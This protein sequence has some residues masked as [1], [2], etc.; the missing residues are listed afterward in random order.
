MRSTESYKNCNYII[1]T[2]ESGYKLKYVIKSHKLPQRIEADTVED[3]K[4][5]LMEYVD[6]NLADHEQFINVALSEDEKHLL[7]KKLTYNKNDIKKVLS[8][9][10][11]LSVKNSVLLE[12]ELVAGKDVICAWLK[13]NSEFDRVVPK[14]VPD[15]DSIYYFNILYNNCKNDFA[16]KQEQIAD[17]LNSR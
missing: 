17:M 14:E 11:F 3:A 12:R 6:G 10:G 7:L 15:Y 5:Q 16:N 1:Y 9:E 8:R 4:N 2:D 13:N